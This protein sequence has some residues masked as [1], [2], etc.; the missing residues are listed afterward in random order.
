MAI[1]DSDG[2]PLSI[3]I[4]EGSRHDISL[5]DR[6]LDAAF[7]FFLARLQPLMS[8]TLKGLIAREE[9]VDKD[10]LNGAST[11]CVSA[12][13]P[14][15]VLNYPPLEIVSVAHMERTISAAKHVQV[16]WSHGASPS[17]SS[18]QASTRL[19][20]SRAIGSDER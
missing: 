5:T 11:S 19:H 17:T 14:L 16:E 8:L 6:T 1:A 2:L 18:G 3:A 7:V 13:C 12:T 15:V 9:L 10:Q 4:A 20:A